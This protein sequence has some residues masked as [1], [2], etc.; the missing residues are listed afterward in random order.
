MPG[1]SDPVSSVARRPPAFICPCVAWAPCGVRLWVPLPVCRRPG[2]LAS[3]GLLVLPRPTSARLIAMPTVITGA[4]R[5]PLAI[6]RFRRPRSATGVRPGAWWS[7]CCLRRL[8]RCFSSHGAVCGRAVICHL[9]RVPMRL[10]LPQR[11]PAELAGA[12]RRP[13][14]L[15]A[16]APSLGGFAVRGQAAVCSST[17]L[18]MRLMT[19][20]LSP[21]HRPATSREVTVDHG[22]RR[23][24]SQRSAAVATRASTRP[25]LLGSR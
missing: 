16:S 23:H 6:I 1:C 19:H 17:R 7:S 13:R 11:I 25:W 5:H 14:R 24:L 2:R 12:L 3:P 10:L 4:T 18:M 8:G 20:L 9:P 15:S 21:R 22:A